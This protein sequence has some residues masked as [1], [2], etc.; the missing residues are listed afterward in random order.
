MN[1]PNV[2]IAN[3][4]SRAGPRVNVRHMVKGSLVHPLWRPAVTYQCVLNCILC[5]IQGSHRIH[6]RQ[7]CKF[8][9]GERSCE[10]DSFFRIEVFESCSPR[11]TRAFAQGLLRI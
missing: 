1:C 11:L 10:K 3:L 7:A 5:G 4:S 9:Q 2:S 8:L 6:F